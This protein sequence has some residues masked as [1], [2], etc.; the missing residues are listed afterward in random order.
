MK[1]YQARG[2]SQALATGS[3]LQTG[4][5]HPFLA[6]TLE[7]LLNPGGRV[8][9]DLRFDLQVDFQSFA[10]LPHAKGDFLVKVTWFAAFPQLLFVD[11][12]A[13]AIQA[14]RFRRYHSHWQ[15]PDLIQVPL[16]NSLL[17][18]QRLAVPTALGSG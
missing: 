18:Q 4:A 13:P 5:E 1:N 2:N 14:L 9:F 10:L 12:F 16:I 8:R 17:L 3:L 15:E 6:A 7:G 11:G